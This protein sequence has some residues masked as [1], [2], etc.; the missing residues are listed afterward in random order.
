MIFRTPEDF[1]KSKFIMGKYRIQ[2]LMLLLIGVSTAFILLI[3]IFSNDLIADTTLKIIAL[4]LIAFGGLVS[5][6]LTL[7]F[8]G[9]HNVLVHLKILYQFHTNYIKRYIWNGHDY[10]E[11]KD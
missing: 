2:D 3:V 4:I 11:F 6:V 9:Y 8:A 7:P 5:A 10:S 1:K